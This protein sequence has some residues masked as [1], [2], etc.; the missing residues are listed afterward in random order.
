[1]KQNSRCMFL[2]E[3]VRHMSTM[4]RSIPGLGRADNDI[5][6]NFLPMLSE[7]TPSHVDASST[8]SYYL[9]GELRNGEKYE[10]DGFWGNPHLRHLVFAPYIL[11]A[12]ESLNFK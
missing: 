9:K 6:P 7:N 11:A 2:N 5:T 4:C 12:E 8:R 3:R 10:A 1:M